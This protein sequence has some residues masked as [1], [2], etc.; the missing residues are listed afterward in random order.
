[1]NKLQISATMRIAIGLAFLSISVL[2]AASFL[3]FIPDRHSAVIE[4]RKALCETIAVSCSLLSR[5][6]ETDRMRATLTSIVKRN[7]DILSAAIRRHSGE[8]VAEVNGHR[9]NWN[10][11]T[12]G[13][14]SSVYAV[15]P[16]VASNQEPW[17][18]VE[19]RFRSLEP[20]GRFAVLEYPM[21]RLS[22]FFPAASLLVYFVYLRKML[23][24]MDPSKVVPGRVRSALDSL[25]SGVLVLDDKARIVLAN[26]SF[27]K[28]IGSSTKELVGSHVANLPWKTPDDEE[29]PSAYNWL[30]SIEEGEAQPSVLLSLHD[31]EADR[32]TFMVKTTP[33]LGD[34][35]RHRGVLASLD[36]VTELQKKELELKRMLEVLTKSRE[37]I[38]HQN[39]ELKKLATQDPLTGCLN[40]RSFFERFET[41]FNTARRYDE[42][43]S[44]V[45]LDL[46]HFKSINDQH[47]HSVGDLV[48]K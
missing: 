42:P 41:L 24:H 15:V 31:G 29:S 4:G 14:D 7:P 2:L 33:I 34:Q 20:Q 28:S 43:L 39:A 38:R 30:K 22:I 27:A 19:L 13:G 35:G 11:G 3:N 12:A 1:M 25:A 8:F 40:R 32:R 26:L 17:G 21:V 45:M 23:R 9:A 44:C 18:T 48:L 47:G 16:I 10:I 5:Q 37:E 36:D 46:D 6:D